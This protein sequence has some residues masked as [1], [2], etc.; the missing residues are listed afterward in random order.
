MNMV[1]AVAVLTGLY[2]VQVSRRSRTSDM[3]AVI[4]HVMPDS[5]AAKAGIQDRRPDRETR[6]QE[7]IPTWEDVGLKEVAS[8]YRPMHLTIERNGKRLRH[9]GDADAEREDRRGVSPDGTSAGEIQ[10]GRRG[11]GHPAEKAGLK[12]GDMLIDA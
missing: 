8:A 12:K 3:Q 1:L 6:R 4:G 7:A 5:P 10:I 11:T 9:D 2:M